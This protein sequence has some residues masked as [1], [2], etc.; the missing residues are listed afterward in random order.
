MLHL[1]DLACSFA[2]QALTIVRFGEL[3]A[4]EDLPVE[5]ALG[6][7]VKILEISLQQPEPASVASV[8]P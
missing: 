3:S 5:Q 8:Q 2:K 1:C 6:P 7:E 4:V